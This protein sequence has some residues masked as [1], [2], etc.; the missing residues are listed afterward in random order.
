MTGRPPADADMETKPAS[1]ATM[2]V[3]VVVIAVL[4]AGFGFYYA[5]ASEEEAALRSTVA[6]QSSVIQSQSTAYSSTVASL[7]SQVSWESSLLANSSKILDLQDSQALVTGATVQIYGS[8][9]NSSQPFVTF[10]AAYAGYVLATVSN[11]TQSFYVNA[12]SDPSVGNSGGGVFQSLTLLAP[13]SSTSILY[14]VIPIA[15]GTE[16]TLALLTTNSTDGT[17]TVTATYFY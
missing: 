11:P 9:N 16:N 5:S 15:P 4:V 2:V 8:N 12:T 10:A 13:S 1:K 3:S 17:A 14:F 7:E 6:S